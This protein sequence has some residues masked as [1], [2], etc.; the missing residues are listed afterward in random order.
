MNLLL[1]A[2]LSPRLLEPL[3]AA[4]YTVEH[5]VEVG[6]LTAS[7][8]AIFDYAAMSG[9]VVVT[10]DSDFPMLLAVRAARAPSVVHL[11]RVAE[12]RPE[13]VAA[14]LLANLPS[15]ADDFERGAVVSLSPERLSVRDLPIR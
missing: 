14:L 4:G 10:A 3:R 6:L 11:R 2:N 13:Q 9:S 8:A 1:D 15:V 5:V 7:D 12:L